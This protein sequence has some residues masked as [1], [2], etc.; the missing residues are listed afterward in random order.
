MKPP[1]CSACGREVK[2]T[3]GTYH[4]KECGLSSVYLMG[5]EIIKCSCGN[6]D[7][8]IPN[9]Q[10]LFEVLALAVLKKPYRL[11]GEDVRFL[12]KHLGMTAEEFSQVLRVDKTTVSKWETNDDV[13]GPQSE[14]LIR[15]VVLLMAKWTIDRP[16]DIIKILSRFDKSPRKRRIRINPVELSYQYA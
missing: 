5:I 4:F 7:P 14:G 9:V 3:R 11:S 6:V 10:Q 1:I 2:I 16:K 8:I 12:R 13:V 15:A